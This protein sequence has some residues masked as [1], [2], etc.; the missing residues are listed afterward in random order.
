MPASTDD[1]RFPAKSKKRRNFAETAMSLDSFP[2][3]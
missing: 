2:S 3:V 1:G